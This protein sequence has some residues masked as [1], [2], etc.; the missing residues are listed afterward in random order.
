MTNLNSRPSA[1][2]PGKPVYN[3]AFKQILRDDVLRCRMDL[4]LLGQ[5]ISMENANIAKF[6]AELKILG[7][8]LPKRSWEIDTRVKWLLGKLMSSQQKLELYEREISVLK[9][10]LKTKD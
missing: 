8:P 7:A 6:E 1:I 9:E 4:A 10:V 3:A 2:K 5:L